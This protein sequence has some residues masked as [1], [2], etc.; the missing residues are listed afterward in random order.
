MSGLP[1]AT[2]P[3][4][5]LVR[6]SAVDGLFMYKTFFPKTVRSPF[7]AYHREASDLLDSTNR[8]V[9]I[10]LPRDGA[11]TS[12]L[13]M[14]T[15]K[16]V[17][18]NLS[19]TII[20]LG[21][22][23]GHAVRSIGWIKRQIESNHF[24]AKTFGLK[25]GNVW[26]D[27]L[28]EIVHTVE[29]NS[30]WIMGLGITGSVRGINFEDHRPDLIV[31][32]DVLTDENA[33]TDDQREKLVSLLLGAVRQSLVPASENP[34]AKMCLLQTPLHVADASCRALLSVEWKS[35]VRGCW[36]E[37]TAD[38]PIELQRS[39]WPGRYPD[40]EMRQQKLAS[41][42]D[43]VYSIFAREKECRLVRK[44]SAAFKLEWL[45]YWDEVPGAKPEKGVI[46]ITVDPVPPPT[47]ETVKKDK[48]GKDFEA[49]AVTMRKDGK[50][51]LLAY[52][53][54]KGHDTIWTCE[55]VWSFVQLF[56]PTQIIIESIGFQ[57][58]VLGAVRN[59]L[60]RQRCH[61]RVSPTDP[62]RNARNKYLKITGALSGVSTAGLFYVSK[63]HSQF[64]ADYEMYPGVSHDDLLDAVAMGVEALQ[65]PY[66]EGA[67]IGSYF[68]QEYKSEFDRPLKLKRKV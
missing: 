12:F 2:L 26:Q 33:S 13:R 50:Y 53:T 61:I 41:I 59:Y 28:I 14:Y 19:R 7:A 29:G 52:S 36:T 38:L 45:R 16:R 27:G 30:I 10:Q 15:A 67:D 1:K 65:N 5:E 43:N 31:G 58:M 55:T 40:S 47:D 17:A 25:K 37:E 63:D 56:R 23:E 4:E 6:L 57:S 11:K 64:R 18:F 35:L 9:N 51:Y 42:A 54:N 60:I 44:E 48:I 68:D 24:F 3:T 66:L 62:K 21:A 49:V 22:S 32:D 20:Y 8:L 34:D 39:S 46:V